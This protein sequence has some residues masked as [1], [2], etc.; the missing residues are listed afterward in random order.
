MGGSLPSKD[1]YLRVLYHTQID[2]FSIS[3][4]TDNSSISKAVCTQEQL[5]P[6][7]DKSLVSTDHSLCN[8]YHRPINISIITKDYELVGNA[9]AKWSLPIYPTNA[10]LVVN[11]YRQPIDISQIS[12]DYRACWNTIATDGWIFTQPILPR[13]STIIV[14]KQITLRSIRAQITFQSTRAQ[15]TLQSA[16]CTALRNSCLSHQ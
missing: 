8:Q 12:R 10:I 3:N 16:K 15:I 5:L 6:S 7:I 13:T 4:S 9:I 2:H 1:S 14:Q 11:E